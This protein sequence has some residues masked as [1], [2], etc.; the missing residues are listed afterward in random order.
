MR[1]NWLILLPF[2]LYYLGAA[3][4]ILAVTANYGVMP[5]VVPVSWDPLL[6]QAGVLLNTRHISWHSSVH[7]A[8]LCDWIQWFD[9]SVQSPGDMLLSLGDWLQPYGLG[10]WVGVNLW[11]QSGNVRRTY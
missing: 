3:L 4:N 5:V 7:L 8:V 10:A 6:N 11:G 9:G 1:K 2:A